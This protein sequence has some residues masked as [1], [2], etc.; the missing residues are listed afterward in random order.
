LAALPEQRIQSGEELLLVPRP[1]NIGDGRLDAGA[2]GIGVVPVLEAGGDVINPVD[3]H[4]ALPEIL[5]DELERQAVRVVRVA[6]PAMT[7]RS[8]V[9]APVR[10]MDRGV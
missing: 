5:E 7:G 4:A 9:V 1:V 6:M 2:D 8:P 3:H 10:C